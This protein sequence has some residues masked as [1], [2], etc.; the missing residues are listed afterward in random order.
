MIRAAMDIGTNSVRLLVGKRQGASFSILEQHAHITRIGEGMKATGEIQTVPLDRTIQ[1]ILG[2]KEILSGYKGLDHLEIV[3]TSAL[4]DARNQREVLERIY[5]ETGFSVEVISGVREAAL[6]YQG[7]VADFPG[8]PVVIDIGGGST[9]VI[10][11][12]EESL[13]FTS[14]DLGA[15]RLKENPS[16]LP[17][18]SPILAASIGTKELGRLADTGARLVGVGGTATTLAAISLGLDEYDWKKVHGYRLS[19]GEIAAIHNRIAS[20]DL[21]ERKKIPGLQAE[22]A[23]IIH[24]GISILETF[25]EDYGF[26]EIRISD[27]DLLFALLFTKPL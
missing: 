26:E 6:S 7:A 12:Q 24:L 21:A 19:K 1:A 20:L 14:A 5:K 11:Q 23:D 10:Y 4:R 22:R 9:E 27:K 16:L 3:A 13:V 15:V 8:N 2:Y 18:I 17:Q 25:M